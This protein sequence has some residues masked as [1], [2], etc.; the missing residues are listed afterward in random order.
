MALTPTQ[1]TTLK[2]DIAANANTI[3]AG[4]PFA[5]TAINALPNN[6][7]ANAEIALWYNGDAS[8]S[9]TV[10]KTSVSLGAIGNAMNATEVAGLTSLN[11]DRLNI[12]ATFSNG[13]IDPSK[14]DRRAAFDDIFSGAGGATTRAALLILWK[15]LAKWIE[16]LFATGTGSDASPATLVYEGSI[17]GNDV[18]LARNLP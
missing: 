9:F 11:L 17:I 7:D 4:R 18:E 15:R 1:L 5:G 13:G 12:L 10:W 3:P 8:P 2:A 16:K 6:S 14:S